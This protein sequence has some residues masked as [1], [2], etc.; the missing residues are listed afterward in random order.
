MSEPYLHLNIENLN[1]QSY[2]QITF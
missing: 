1:S 2:Q